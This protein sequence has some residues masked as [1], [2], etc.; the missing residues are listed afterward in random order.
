MITEPESKELDEEGQRLLES[1]SNLR[2]EI[3]GLTALE[4]DVKAQLI[5]Y[6]DGVQYGTIDGMSVVKVS[7]VFTERP[8]YETLKSNPMYAEAIKAHMISGE[9]TRVSVL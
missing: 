4:A 5:K 3:K 6:L 1:L 9:H 8:D 7:T 2:L